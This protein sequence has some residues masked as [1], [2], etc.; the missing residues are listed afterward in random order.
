V[1]TTILVLSLDLSFFIPLS[2]FDQ[3]VHEKKQLDLG[4]WSGFLPDF[5]ST[6][7]FHLTVMMVAPLEAA[8]GFEVFQNILMGFHFQSRP[9]GC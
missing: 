5:E 2:K 3:G 4:F 6:G 7:A 9:G 8:V 1:V